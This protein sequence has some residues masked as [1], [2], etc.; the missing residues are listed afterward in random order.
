MTDVGE[1]EPDYTLYS[2]LGSMYSGKARGYMNYK[3][4][5]YIDQPISILDMISIKRNTGEAVMPAVKTK[6]GEWLQDT[7]IIIEELE[8]RH[9]ERS[10]GGQEFQRPILHPSPCPVQAKEGHGGSRERTGVRRRWNQARRGA[11]A[12]VEG[13]FGAQRC[14]PTTAAEMR[15]WGWLEFA[16]KRRRPLSR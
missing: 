16:K 15:R 2:A 5:N 4:L 12:P 1:I 7:T 13:E 10:I 6:D 3:K 14:A 9:P 11:R 8:K